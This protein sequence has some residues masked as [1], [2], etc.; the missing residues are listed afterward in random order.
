MLVSPNRPSLGRYWGK[1]HDNTGRCQRRL[2]NLTDIV[3]TGQYRKATLDDG[4][5]TN[6]HG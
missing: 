1:Y 3:F 6:P 2:L 5:D 4:M